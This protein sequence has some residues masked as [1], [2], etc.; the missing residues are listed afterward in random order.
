MY[1]YL[2]KKL[3]HLFFE[4]DEVKELTIVIPD[5]FYIS[6]HRPFESCRPIRRMPNTR[7]PKYILQLDSDSDSDSSDIDS[8]KPVKKAFEDFKENNKK[9]IRNDFK[10]LFK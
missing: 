6:N 8:E 4:K 10:T 2:F 3:Y 7:K 9:E 5:N 1:Y